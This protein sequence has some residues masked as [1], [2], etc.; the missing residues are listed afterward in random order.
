MH[1]DTNYFKGLPFR[2]KR[3]KALNKSSG[4]IR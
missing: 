1:A 3:G 2:L 4:K